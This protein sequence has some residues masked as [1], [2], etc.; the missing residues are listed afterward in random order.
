MAKTSLSTAKKSIIYLIYLVVIRQSIGRYTNV[1]LA[2]FLAVSDRPDSSDSKN[3]E[4]TFEDPI[5]S[6]SDRKHQTFVDEGM[7][8]NSSNVA[9]CGK[10]SLDPGAV[11]SSNQL[12]IIY[13]N[14]EALEDPCEGTCNQRTTNNRKR[15]EQE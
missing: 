11:T 15:K 3:S 6:E 10:M 14:G 8:S 2:K 12:N 13:N 5:L 7:S 4:Q 9:E 1:P